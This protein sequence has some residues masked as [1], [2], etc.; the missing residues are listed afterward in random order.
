MNLK[1]LNGIEEKVKDLIPLRRM[2]CECEMMGILWR[3]FEWNC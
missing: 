3:V 1:L 2:R